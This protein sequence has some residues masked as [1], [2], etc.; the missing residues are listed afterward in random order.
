MLAIDTFLP[1]NSLN[2][3]LCYLS[4]RDLRPFS[5]HKGSTA[6][7]NDSSNPSKLDPTELQA[8]GGLACWLLQATQPLP[9]VTESVNVILR[10]FISV[11][12]LAVTI[13]D[14]VESPSA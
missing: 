10:G 14:A 9:L 3:Y 11:G 12:K 2:L 6:D 4:V 8:L 5:P 1:L 7:L 13:R